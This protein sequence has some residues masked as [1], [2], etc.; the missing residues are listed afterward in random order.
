MEKKYKD[1]DDKFRKVLGD[2]QEPVPPYMAG[3]V[4]SALDEG[5]KFVPVSRPEGSRILP[6]WVRRLS[7]CVAVAAVVALTFILFRPEETFMRNHSNEGILAKAEK[8]D[9]VKSPEIVEIVQSPTE[10]IAYAPSQTEV[11]SRKPSSKSS[12]SSHSS[13]VPTASEVLESLQPGSSLSESGQSVSEQSESKQSNSANQDEKEVFDDPFAEPVQHTRK[14]PRVTLEIESGLASNSNAKGL[15]HGAGGF[16]APG[17]G[18]QNKTWI[19]QTGEESS[20]SIPLSVSFGAKVYL[21]E[22]WALGTGLQYTYLQRTFSGVYNNTVNGVNNRISTDISHKIHYVGVPLNVYYGVLNSPRVKMYAFA[23]G[24]MEKGFG[25]A[26]VVRNNPGNIVVNEDVKGLQFSAGLGFGVEFII[27]DH[28]SFYLDPGI[29]YYFDCHQP[30]SI[31]TQ[32]PLMMNFD[33][34]FRLLL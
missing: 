17:N 8:A 33:I 9:E 5:N 16:R 29:R 27:S 24:T 32:Q 26:Y 23:G 19:Q 2:A 21:T 7:A 15:E 25:N 14:R 30:T 28:F 1:F 10:R 22:H 11:N 18:V 12:S 4:F 34:G 3:R 20:Y 13:V 6:P 31:R